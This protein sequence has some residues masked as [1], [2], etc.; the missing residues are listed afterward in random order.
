MTV[1]DAVPLER[2]TAR[3]ALMRIDIAAAVIAVVS[4]L[5]WLLGYLLARIC[6]AVVAG[7]VWSAAAVLVGWDDA[8]KGRGRGSAR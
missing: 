2:I 8:R 4:A 6:S 7:V 5:L 1:L 3:A